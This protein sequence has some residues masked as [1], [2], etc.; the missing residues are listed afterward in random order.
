M[1]K[2]SI[3]DKRNVITNHSIN[4]KRHR[5]NRSINGKNK[6]GEASV[7]VTTQDKSLEEGH[8]SF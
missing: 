1:L 4:G 7:N 5:T 2:D 3:D 6:S 8:I